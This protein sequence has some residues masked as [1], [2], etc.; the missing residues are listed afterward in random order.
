LSRFFFVI[1]VGCA[2]E[3]ADRSAA[4]GPPPQSQSQTN[5]PSPTNTGTQAGAAGL[6]W[7]DASGAE[8]HGVVTLPEGLA[9]IDINGNVWKLSA[10]NGDLSDFGTLFPAF[11]DPGCTQPYFVLDPTEVPPL[12]RHVLR[13]EA[14]DTLYV[15][16]DDVPYEPIEVAYLKDGAAC[17]P[18][19]VPLGVP[20]TAVSIVESLA[21]SW[22]A[23]IHPELP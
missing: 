16:S 10:W 5:G 15:L 11:T 14:G 23:P 1:L 17:E 6:R 20:A 19:E 8:I 9:H 2:G 12:P 13:N 18:I 3:T 7:V 21:P 22:T 4:S